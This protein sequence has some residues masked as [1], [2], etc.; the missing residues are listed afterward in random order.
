MSF[1]NDEYGKRALDFVER[2]QKLR[3][4]EEISHEIIKEMAAFGFETVSCFSVPRAGEEIKDSLW[5]NTRPKDYIE[6][7]DEKKYFDRD[8]II[9]EFRR[10]LG[11]FSWNDVRQNRPLNKAER[12]I[13]DEAQEW[14]ANDGLTVPIITL[15]GSIAGFC[16]CGRAPDLSPR[17]RAAVELIGIYSHNALRRALMRAARDQIIH[18]PFT[19]REREVVKWVAAGKSDSEIGEILNIST[20]TVT[21]HVENAKKKV[22]AIRRPYLVFQAL[23]CGEISL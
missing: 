4:Y 7:Y 3:G 14:D 12:T 5:I 13:I 10:N 9:S 21:A 19:P 22:D 15:S 17:G 8:P 23:R 6:R 2:L 11:P 1:S 18:T 16:P 20:T